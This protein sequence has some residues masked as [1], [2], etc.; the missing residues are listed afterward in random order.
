LHGKTVLVIDD[1]PL[2]CQLM[3]AIYASAGAQVYTALDGEEG[4]VAFRERRPDLLLIDVL[5][6]GVDGLEVCRRIRRA[7][8]VP[9]VMFTVLNRGSD[10]VRGLDAGADDYVAKPFNRDV[11][12]ARS[13]A[14]LRRAELATPNGNH[15]V[16]DD[17]Y[18][19]LDVDSKQV[20]VEGRPVDLTST[21]FSLLG[22]LFK[23]AG[24]ARTFTQILDDVWGGESKYSAEHA[25]VFIWHLRQKMEPDPRNP[26]YLISEPG[27]GYRFALDALM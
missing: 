20:E 27:I 4:L 26:T 23:N 11:L 12:L 24:R 21:E 8:D 18:L 6:P 25:H 17:G 13:R 1:E 10:V 19:R 5:M 3:E 9:I 16:Y 2:M 22:Y 7:S 15:K 14:L